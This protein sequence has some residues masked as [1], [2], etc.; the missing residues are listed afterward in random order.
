MA[1]ISFLDIPVEKSRLKL[2]AQYKINY[3]EYLI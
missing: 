1:A 3:Y 2:I